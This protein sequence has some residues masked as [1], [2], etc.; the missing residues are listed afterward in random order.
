MEPPTDIEVEPEYGSSAPMVESPSGNPCEL[1]SADQ[2]TI[3][4]LVGQA[5]ASGVSLTGPDGLLKLLT[6]TV[7]EAALEEEMSD[8]LGYEKHDLL[9]RNQGNSRNG[10]R[11]KT[12][13]T[14]TCGDV[15]IDVPR[16]RDGSFEPV[17]VKK[18]QR[19]LGGLDEMV[20]SL[21]AKGLTS[22]EISAHL[23]DMY[24]H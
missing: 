1:T 18:R 6:K 24:G 9:G 10:T 17:I 12:V 7:L 19:R 15:M 14:D 13:I 3:V 8:H 5:R 16:D 20:L 22:G 4:E 23:K 21:Y 11:S 2:A